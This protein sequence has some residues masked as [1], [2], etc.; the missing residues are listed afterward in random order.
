MG[1][2]DE[3]GPLRTRPLTA[4]PPRWRRN[5]ESS[6]PRSVSG[7]EDQG[8]RAGRNPARLFCGGESKGRRGALGASLSVSCR[9]SWRRRRGSWRPGRGREPGKIPCGQRIVGNS[10]LFRENMRRKGLGFEGLAEEFPA[11]ASR[12]FFGA[13]QG[14]CRGTVRSRD[15]RASAKNAD[16]TGL[17]PTFG[18][19]NL[20]REIHGRATSPPLTPRLVSYRS[21]QPSRDRATC[22]PREIMGMTLQ[23]SDYGLERETR[24]ACVNPGSS[25]ARRTRCSRRNQFF[26]TSLARARMNA[27]G[28]RGV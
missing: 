8:G 14:M 17:R 20:R 1:Q 2:G 24:S 28:R 12:D 26:A 9:W 13:E 10:A 6:S 21:I 11:R 25:V 18:R 15:F 19:F 5:G 4:S 3:P 23:P 7:E 16:D 22:H 27:C